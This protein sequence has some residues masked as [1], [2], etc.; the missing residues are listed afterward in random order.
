MKPAEKIEG[1]G[2]KAL[3]HSRAVQMI[4]HGFGEEDIHLVGAI[5]AAKGPLSMPWTWEISHIYGNT[6]PG[7]R[8]RSP[9]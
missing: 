2:N 4:V 7:R 5:L 9:G 1:D 8:K 6:R 3:A